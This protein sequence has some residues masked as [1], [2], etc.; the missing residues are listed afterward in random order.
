MT[1]AAHKVTFD[2][3]AMWLTLSDGHILGVP[4]VWFPRLLN[5]TPE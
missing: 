4:L 3:D 1:I 2:D 5:A